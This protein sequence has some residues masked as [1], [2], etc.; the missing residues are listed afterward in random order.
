MYSGCSTIKGYSV[1]F[2][3][4]C[5]V[6]DYLSGSFCDAVLVWKNRYAEIAF[7]AKDGR[8]RLDQDRTTPVAVMQRS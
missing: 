7:A 6:A 8:Y 5:S 2:A 4:V 3:P 1:F